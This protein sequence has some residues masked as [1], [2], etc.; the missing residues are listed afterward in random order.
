MD[1]W[2][3][4]VSAAVGDKQ[5]IQ[6]ML[7]MFQTMQAPNYDRKPSS[8]TASNTANAPDAGH[9]LLAEFAYRLSMCEKR[10]ASLEQQIAGK[11]ESKTKSA[12]TTAPKSTTNGRA[13]PGSHRGSKKPRK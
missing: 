3:K 2:Q 12:K 1:L 13:K 6:T 10:I 5:F 11:K 4:Q 9:E 7:Q 8:A